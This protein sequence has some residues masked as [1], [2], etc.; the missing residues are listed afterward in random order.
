MEKA[1]EPGR[2]EAQIYERW[3]KS[4]AFKPA[5][6]GE[7]FTIIMP[8][9]NANGDLH[10]GHAMYV[11]EDILIRYHRMKGDRTLWLP[12]ADHAG[13]E[14]QVVFERQLAKDGKSRFDL[15]REE[16]YRQVWD[17]TQAN[18]GKMTDQVRSLG[19]SVDWSRFKFTLDDDIVSTVNETFKR[20][21]DDG[22][23][24]RG[25]RIVN[26]C[27]FCRSAFADIEV[28]YREQ[29]DPLYY[30]KYGPFVLATVRPET[31]FGDTAIAVNPKDERYKKYVGQTIEAE[32]LNGPIKLQVIADDYVNPEF[33]TGVV[34]VTPAHDPNDW[35]M[36][37]RHN[38][39]VKQAIGT[40]GLLT[41]LTGRYAGMPVAEARQQVA[42]DLEE[43]GLIDHIDM[44]YNHSVGYH[45]RCGTLI[46]PL[47]V[48]QW[49]LKVDE[50]K[51][52]VIKAIKDGEVT[53][54]P[55]RF[56]KVALDW[57]EN[58]R[59]WNISRQNWWGIR[60]PAYYNATGDTSLPEYVIG[61]EAEAE[62]V[63]GKSGYEAETDNFDTWFSSGQWPFAT[64]MATDSM[65]FYPTSVM[66][67]GRDIL[68]LWVTRMIMFGLY[69]TGQVPFRTVYLHG[70]VTDG[71]GKKMSKSKGNVINPLAMTDKYGTDALRLGLTVGITPGN[72]GALSEAKIEGYRN[73]CNKL[74]NVARFIQGQL[75]DGYSPARPEPKTPADAWILARINDAARDVTRHIETYRF[76][77]AG[78]AVYSLLWDDFAD[79][80]VEASKVEQNPN[81]LYHG[82]T[83]ILKLA[84]P[85]APFVTEAIW[86][87]L[88]GTDGQLISAEWPQAV[89][90]P[91]GLLKTA[92][93]FEQVKEV[94]AAARAVAA[95]EQINRP[96]VL[97]TSRAVADASELV[98]RL[99]RADR[100]ELVEQ[101]SGLYLGSSEPA[102][103]EAAPE[104]VA[105]RRHHLQA[106]R[107]ARQK[108]AAGLEKQLANRRFVE[109][110]PEAVVA[111]TKR[112]R[113]EAL[114]LVSKLD[115]QLKALEP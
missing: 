2:Y 58:L 45:D 111:D 83:T 73:F 96:V 21:H 94:I 60:I 87:A 114:M 51:K 93:E 72:D 41:E 82:L 13:I 71:S 92:G 113:D 77:E 53:F 79:W 70:L 56:K 90:A 25:N 86:D 16:F 103:I 31:K 34:K 88:P 20:L 64:L 1:Y 65:D 32:D 99:A 3:E 33:G 37:L 74:W 12:G 84:H 54:V 11:V 26:W 78:Q 91:S 27:P 22:L 6:K 106:D 29:I 50:L 115:E 15:G 42:H 48:E 105:K 59:D 10:L 5:G 28:K 62:K 30:I 95:E 66:E 89:K 4:G 18:M 76:S 35:E 7:P 97:T 57:M 36:G 85:F 112:R 81:I 110:A 23:I 68:F 104:A 40:D 47:V 61:T 98:T 38:L 102:W 109:S 39:E 75:P 8:P 46:E 55:S 69:R 107:D 63:Y 67:T 100:V 80:Y 52:P 19:F 44:N 24:Y 49:W 9:P 101:G 14:T 17:F 108:Y 43:R